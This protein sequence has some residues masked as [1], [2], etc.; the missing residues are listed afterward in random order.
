MSRPLR[1]AHLSD[2]HVGHVVA[3]LAQLRRMFLPKG[4]AGLLD[5]A[6]RLLASSWADRRS[7]I[8]PLFRASHL[9]HGYQT[10]NLVAVA[11]AV[12]SND[13]A[14]VIL[15]G[16]LANLGAASEWREAIAVL[17]AA[18]YEAGTLSIVPGNHDVINFR[19]A[20]LPLTDRVYPC[21]DRIGPHL[22]VLNVDT[23]AH[24]PEL[25]WRDT[26]IMNSRGIVRQADI[27]TA[28]RLLSEVPPSVFKILAC[29][30][31]LVDLP[32]DGYV[33]EWSDRLDKRLLGRA[34]NA[35]ALLDV[36]Q[37]R[38]VGLILFGHR[39]RATHDQF[40][41]RDIPAACSGSVTEVGDRGTMRFRMFEFDG[42]ALVG[43][44]WVEVSPSEASPE[45]VA[46]AIEEVSALEGEPQ[47]VASESGVGPLSERGWNRVRGRLKQVDRSVLERMAR[48]MGARK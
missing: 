4:G 47:N 34:S 16:D 5:I 1:V 13:A 48:R 8:E 32:P 33:D 27:D 29:H 40:T 15:T 31:H 22:C 41:I 25:D 43:R 2:L 42:P 37:A 39:H 14:H 6:T 28:D 44:R 3:N 26:L 30:H 38:G 24:L 19:G 36:A 21:L 10:R 35:E 17:A 11:Q 7:L 45:A 9:S 12:R 20:P 23:T 46:K 18:G